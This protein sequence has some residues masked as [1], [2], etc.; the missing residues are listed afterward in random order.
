M[1]S[2][3]NVNKQDELKTQSSA[4]SKLT[5]NTEIINNISREHKS[6]INSTEDLTLVSEFVQCLL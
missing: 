2:N 1:L 6:I 3:N 5:H 4:S